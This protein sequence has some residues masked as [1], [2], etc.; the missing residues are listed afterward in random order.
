MK[1]AGKIL[2]IISYF[3]FQT[4]PMEPE[5]EIFRHSEPPLSE[6]EELFKSFWPIL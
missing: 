2:L 4:K 5:Q 6:L 1:H 3:T